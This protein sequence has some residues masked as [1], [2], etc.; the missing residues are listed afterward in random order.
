MDLKKEFKEKFWKK[1]IYWNYS[2]SEKN[3][4][5]EGFDKGWEAHEQ[6]LK[7]KPLIKTKQNQIRKNQIPDDGC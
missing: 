5:D 2:I 6:F 4:W 3:M 7:E 1:L